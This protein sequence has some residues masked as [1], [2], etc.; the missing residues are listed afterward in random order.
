MERKKTINT[1]DFDKNGAAERL[2]EVIGEVKNEI[3]SRVG[4]VDDRVEGIHRDVRDIQM[5][6]LQL[7]KR[8]A[9]LESHSAKQAT[10]DVVSTLKSSIDLLGERIMAGGNNKHPPHSHNPSSYM[11]PST[12]IDVKTESNKGSDIDWL[13]IAKWLGII[14]MI[15]FTSIIGGRLGA[16]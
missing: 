1:M 10:S 6:V 2:E 15:F 12:N 4:I 14:F 5:T 9:I 11:S 7:D 8:V 3:L 16:P 13:R